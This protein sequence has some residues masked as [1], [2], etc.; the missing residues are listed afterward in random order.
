MENP[1]AEIEDVILAIT[2]SLNPEIQRAAIYRKPPTVFPPSQASPVHYSYP[3][4]LP[5]LNKLPVFVVRLLTPT[6]IATSSSR[7]TILRVYQWYRVLSPYLHVQVKK[8][9]YD[10]PR[11]EIYAEIV[12]RF[13]V[14]WNVFMPSAESRLITHVTLRELPYASPE[15]KPLYVIAAQEDFY[16]P[17]DL[18]T[19]V[20]PLLVPFL[21]A[22]L[23]LGT[24]ACV[25]GAWFGG[26]LGYWSVRPGERGKDVELQHIGENAPPPEQEE[27]SY[28]DVTKHGLV[29]GKKGSDEE[30]AEAESPVAE[31]AS[32][33]W[34]TPEEALEVHE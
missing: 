11:K 25:L 21:L 29:N 15:G 3:L 18:L 30:E 2:A 24:W 32:K 7:E 27:T 34:P 12:Q 8:V 9:V 33:E 28:A 6:G 16:H 4:S 20:A 23:L 14:R 13:H 10:E 1:A 5:Y 22:L 19:F 17:E 26:A 31:R